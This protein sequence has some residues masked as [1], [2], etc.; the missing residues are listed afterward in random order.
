MHQYSSYIL[1]LLRMIRMLIS[2]IT[3]ILLAEFFGVSLERDIWV[4]ASTITVTVTNSV[5][6]PLNEI[7][8][9]KFIFIRE[10]QGESKAL[11]MTSSL[12]GFIIF[13]S[14]IICV[15]IALFSSKIIGYI[16]PPSIE[17]CHDMFKVLLI[18]LLPTILINE[19]TNICISVLNAFDIFYIPELVAIF[20]SIFSIIIIYYVTPLYGIYSLLVST[21][22]SIVVLLVILLILLQQ[23]GIKIFGKL[24]AFKFSDALVFVSYSL[25]LFL[26]YF[27][28][29]CNSFTEKVLSG[30]LGPGLISSLEYSRQFTT[31]LQGVLSSVITTIM[32]PQLSKAYV[33]SNKYEYCHIIKN[34]LSFV[35]FILA[36]ALAFMVGCPEFLCDFLFN[37]GSISANY[38]ETI[39]I[40]TCCFGIAFIGVALYVIIGLSLLSSNRRKQYATIGVFT[41]VFVMICNFTLIEISGVYIFPLSYG[42]AHL[43]AAIVM[44][45]MLEINNKKILRNKIA[46]SIIIVLVFSLL[47]RLI[48]ILYLNNLSVIFCL[49]IVSI[50]VIILSP[51]LAFLLGI[52]VRKLIKSVCQ[53]K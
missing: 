17:Y 39:S 5:W 8:R 30:G 52:D 4:L 32:I 23:K 2:I 10:S 46:V 12:I 9:T 51:V 35:F 40:L 20:T 53:K 13:I 36:I 1:F 26:P 16:A 6:G 43:V 3:T 25:P 47:I 50:V 15:I 33:C 41:Q 48:C 29:Q 14:I 49:V 37:R 19:I 31:I 38:L 11:E 7:F 22:V 34:N 42:L 44:F 24:V 18:L 45:S 28:G 27:T 21:Y